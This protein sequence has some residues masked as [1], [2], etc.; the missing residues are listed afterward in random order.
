[1]F[2]VT[3]IARL[4]A[5]VVAA[6]VVSPT[7]WAE[8]L[9]LNPGAEQ[10]KGDNPSVWDRASVAADGL[11]MERNTTVVKEGKASL[12]IANDHKYDKPVANNWMQSLQKVPHGVALRVAAEIRTRDADSA[13]VC[14]QCWDITGE[15]MLA[16]GST[17]VIRGDQEWI[18]VT[19]DPV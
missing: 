7:V 15:K 14:V 13:N 6:V 8:N 5:F 11:K 12:M 18:R 10:G 4:I 2:H 9:L 17:P 3:A 1:M 19:S 16:F